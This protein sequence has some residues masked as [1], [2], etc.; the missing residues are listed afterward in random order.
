MVNKFGAELEYPRQ[1]TYTTGGD[2]NLVVKN[3][4]S[5]VR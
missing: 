5:A 3:T 4:F 2:P 1:Y